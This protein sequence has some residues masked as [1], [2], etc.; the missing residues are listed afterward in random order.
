MLTHDDVTVPNAIE[1]FEKVKDTT[2]SHVGFKDI[3]LPFEKMRKLVDIM[4]KEERE[5]LFEAVSL[6]KEDCLQSVDT[7][8]KLGVDYF[9]G[10]IYH[11]P[12][13]KLLRSNGIKYFPYV[14]RV[15]DHP[16]LLRG[17]IQDVVGDAREA[18]ASG[19]DGINLLAYRYKGDVDRLMDSVKNAVDIPIIVAGDINSFERINQVVARGIWGFTIGSA[20]FEKKFSSS[21]SIADQITAVMAGVERTKEK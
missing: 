19:M 11:R 20:I 3:G 17:S 13:L 1:V 10:G 6:T 5:V 14:G 16:C 9:I 18:A 15:V 7:A 4:K 21:R 12:I 8:V 2:V